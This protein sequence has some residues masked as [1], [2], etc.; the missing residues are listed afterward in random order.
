MLLKK[1]RKINLKRK[2]SEA[3]AKVEKKAPPSQPGLEPGSS[4]Y[5]ADALPLELLGPAHVQISSVTP[6]HHF[7]SASQHKPHPRPTW[8]YPLP[9]DRHVAIVHLARTKLKFLNWRKGERL[10]LKRKGSEAFAKVEK[11]ASWLW[12]WPLPFNFRKCFASLS[13][14]KI[15]ESSIPTG[16]RRKINWVEKLWTAWLSFRSVDDVPEVHLRKSTR[17]Y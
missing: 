12:R 14:L 17:K 13:F 15:A 11:K 3:F 9:R 10:N 8:L 7:A 2:G 6:S 4:A 5:A 16:T 1:G